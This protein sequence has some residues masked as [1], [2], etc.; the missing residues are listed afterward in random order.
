MPSAQQLL[1]FRFSGWAVLQ[2]PVKTDPALGVWA[3]ALLQQSVD[4][5]AAQGTLSSA[6]FPF[7]TM[8]VRHAIGG[9]TPLCLSS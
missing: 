7:Q 3:L 5:Q 1:P 6:S 9:L 4:Q 2:C 8:D